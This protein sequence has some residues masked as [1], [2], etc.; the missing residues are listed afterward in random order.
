MVD[1]Q[2]NKLSLLGPALIPMSMNE[3]ENNRKSYLQ[4][5]GG[6]REISANSLEILNMDGGEEEEKNQSKWVELNKFTCTR[7]QKRK[8]PFSTRT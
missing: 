4:L 2:S 1:T 3:Y 8:L 6:S 5:A 7:K